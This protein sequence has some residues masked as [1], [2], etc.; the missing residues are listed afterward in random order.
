MEPVWRRAIGWTEASKEGEG[1]LVTRLYRA[2]AAAIRE[3]RLADGRALPSSR[4]AAE[5]LDVS[6]N[7]VIAAY[8]L[9][10]ADGLIALHPGRA[11][12]VTYRPVV[13]P[14]PDTAAGPGLSAR[15][16]AL[17]APARDRGP[18]ALVM[19]PGCPDE[20]EFPGDLWGR[21]LRRAARH[22]HG[23]SFGYG[24]FHGLAALRAE[25]VERLAMDRGMTVDAGQILV[26]PGTQA[27]L[28]LAATVLADP[29][30]TA[31]IE[32]P[33]Y[34]GARAA[35]LGAGLNLQPLPVD[36]QGADPAA[37]TKMRD[38]RLVYLTPSNQFPLGARLPLGRRQ[39]ILAAA[40]AAGAVVL[41]DDYD[42]EFQW[43]GQEIAAMQAEA[44]G[45]EVIYLGT[46]AKALMPGLRLSWMVLPPALVAAMRV[47]QRNLGL[48]ANLH[49]QAALADLMRSGQYR[50]HLRR[51]ARLN[52]ERG[53]A[54]VA[55]LKARL[56]NRISV[57]L[58]D[59]GVQL[60]I[61]LET[62]A[63]E[64]AALAALGRAGF[65]AAALSGYG[66]TGGHHG[67][68]TGFA[69]ATADRI[70]RFVATLAAAL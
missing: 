20:A 67:L 15:G 54:L 63:E 3:G 40:S 53:E 12:V 57:A 5:G 34:I 48:A 24:D 66:L 62:G 13:V 25:L 46:A 22:R 60:A 58:P 42:G 28:S 43:R 29:G 6:R 65:G 55:A 39:A 31:A 8:D 10:R 16:A 61:R 68:V 41:E 26:L 52:R 14:V 32:D 35:F 19:A 33:G 4:K 21:A 64:S 45:G 51:I 69:D 27:A 37:L 59:G 36:D 17:A 7:T 49:A 23:A 47:T 56:G 70:E 50:A 30:Q 1:A 38:L 2:F 44:K 18:A 11:P 9:L